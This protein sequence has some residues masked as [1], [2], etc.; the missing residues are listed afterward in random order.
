MASFKVLLAIAM[1]LLLAVSASAETFTTEAT[2]KEIA[3]AAAA[4]VDAPV[5]HVADDDQAEEADEEADEPDEETDA[6]LG[7]DG[8]SSRGYH[9]RKYCWRKWY[10]HK[11][12]VRSYHPCHHYSH[13]L[14]EAS[15]KVAEVAEPHTAA[16][17]TAADDEAD[18]G[19]EDVADTVA[20][21]GYRKYWYC[22]KKKCY[23]KKYCRYH[24]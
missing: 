24:H 16:P 18:A 17:L 20:S 9:K 14:L 15:G 8:A 3:T 2:P 1:A 23:W 11:Y 7:L 13:R 19:V 10:C 5:V 6:N 12:R 21:R 4:A 22:Y